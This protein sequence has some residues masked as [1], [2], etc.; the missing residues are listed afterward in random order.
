MKKLVERITDVDYI[1][2]V[3]NALKE[4]KHKNIKLT[5]VSHNKARYETYE[6]KI[7]QLGYDLMDFEISRDYLRPNLKEGDKIS[8]K[9]VDVHSYGTRQRYH[10]FRRN[11][12]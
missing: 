10:S 3:R 2:N 4:D 7:L 6:G 12:R 5:V 9:L 11:R 8:V 1:E